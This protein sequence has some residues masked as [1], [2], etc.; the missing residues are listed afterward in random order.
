MSINYS[1]SVDEGSD[2]RDDGGWDDDND[3]EDDNDRK[4]GDKDDL[5]T[6]DNDNIDA[7]YKM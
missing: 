5:I 2:N 7:L 4:N 1:L 6:A 3:D